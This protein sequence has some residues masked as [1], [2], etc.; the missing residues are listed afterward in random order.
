METEFDFTKEFNEF[1]MNVGSNMILHIVKQTYHSVAVMY[2]TD[3]MSK[4]INIP[5]GIVVYENQEIQEPH[6]Q[7]YHLYWTDNYT[8]EYKN[9]EILH[10]VSQRKWNIIS[11]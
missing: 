10:L 2:F 7:E 5:D 4:K 3:E 6:R 9:T 11:H 1:T 8:I